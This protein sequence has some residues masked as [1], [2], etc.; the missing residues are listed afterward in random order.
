VRVGE[1]DLGPSFFKE[2]KGY[3]WGLIE[4]RPYMRAK[5]T[6]AALL[7]KM[8]FLEAAIEQ[9]EELLELNP[10]DNQGIR[11]LLLP[12]YIES[13]SFDEALKLLNAYKD[14]VSATLMF[15]RALVS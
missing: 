3:F 11:D 7:D 12:L 6:Y 8:G 4:T 9:Y 15:S 2:N 5:A 10:N 13:E 14:D 1:A